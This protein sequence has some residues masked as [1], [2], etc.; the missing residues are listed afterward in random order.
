M[1]V[2]SVMAAMAIVICGATP[3]VA[4]GV[5]RASA[6]GRPNEAGALPESETLQTY[7]EQTPPAVEP[8]QL[9][10]LDSATMPLPATA[11]PLAYLALSAAVALAAAASLARLERQSSPSK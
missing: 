6:A 1:R 10:R 7:G 5:D 3:C 4:D 11:S 8:A 2:P 9:G